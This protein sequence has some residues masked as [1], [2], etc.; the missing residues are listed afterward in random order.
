MIIYVDMDDVITDLIGSWV[1]YLDDRY[2]LD[3]TPEDITDWD[4]TKSFPTLSKGAVFAPLYE[5]EFWE[6][7]SPIDDARKY[8]L[9]L[10]ADGHKIYIVTNSNYQT[11]RSK[12]EKVLF[13]FFPFLTWN[14]VIIMRD[15]YLL[16]GDVIVDD[17]LSNILSFDGYKILKDMPHNQWVS[18]KMFGVTRGYNWEHIYKL[19]SHI[20]KE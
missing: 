5:D 1:S 2:D 11:L 6:W 19:I 4:V 7:V 3:V 18:E 12:M 8:L 10:M 17:C 15:K 14:D 20:N 9:Q 13:T 16:K